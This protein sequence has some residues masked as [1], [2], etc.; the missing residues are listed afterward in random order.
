MF[1]EFHALNNESISRFLT[2]A[3]GLNQIPDHLARTDAL[4]M[5]QANLGLWQILARQGQIP[6]ARLND[7]WQKILNAFGSLQTSDQVYEAGRTALAEL[8]RASTGKTYLPQDQLFA[9]LA[10]PEQYTQG[11]TAATIRDGQQNAPGD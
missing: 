11:G 4:G 7:S 9:L 10:G 6:D 5:L 8:L 3:E 1:A 2:V